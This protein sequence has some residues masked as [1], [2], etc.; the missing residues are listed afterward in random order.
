[1]KNKALYIFGDLDD[2]VLVK[3]N[4]ISK[5]IKNN[6]LTQ[7]VD[8]PTRV[9]P[10]SSTLL[11]LVITNKPDVINFCD[12]VTQE[13]ADHDLISITADISKSK[14]P[15]V[16]RTFRHLGK[17]T[18]DAFC[19]RLLQNKHDFNMILQTDDLNTQVDI[20]TENFIKCLNDC[21]P[22]ITKEIKR[23]FTQWMNDDIREAMNLR[24]D[25]R[26]NLKSDRYNI[27]L[28]EQYK[29]EKKRVKTL[30]KKG[31][32]EHYRN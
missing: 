22:F 28:Q 21:A 14:R 2:N 13:I 18:K 32:A 8:K 31:K 6:K 25:T 30:I 5:I 3:D 15:P 23:P 16:V 7:M 17:Y 10:T 11:N 24:D 20:F 4:K 26:K 12:F 19:L 29:H 27:I 1:M 9:T